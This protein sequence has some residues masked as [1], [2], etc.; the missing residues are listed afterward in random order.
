M[1]G[2]ALIGVGYYS[3][4]EPED[5]FPSLSLAGLTEER[6]VLGNP[7]SPGALHYVIHAYDQPSSAYRALT[8]AYRYLNAS[9]SVPHA[10]HMPSHIFSDLGLWSDMVYSNVLSLNKAFELAGEP[11]GDWYHGYVH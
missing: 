1:Y 3:E 4:T 10:L 7:D 8:S 2:L 6:V 11:T 9:T 5:G